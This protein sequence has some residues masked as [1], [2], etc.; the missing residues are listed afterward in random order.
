MGLPPPLLSRSAKRDVKK[1]KDEG[2]TKVNLTR[3]GGPSPS[4]THSSSRPPVSSCCNTIYF[5]PSKSSSRGV[6][7]CPPDLCV[8]QGG[9]DRGGRSF[10]LEEQSDGWRWQVLPV[11]S[12]QNGRAR[13]EGLGIEVTEW[14]VSG[15]EVLE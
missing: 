4:S 1:G 15:M 13:G 11:K 5:N 7:H 3:Q 12:A 2:K 14:R 9:Q 8:P 10:S 6:S